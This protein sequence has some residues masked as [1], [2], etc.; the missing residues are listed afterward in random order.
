MTATR[1]CALIPPCPVAGETE[2]NMKYVFKHL[3]GDVIEVE[4]STETWARNE[5]M[6]QKWGPP[7]P[8]TF[9]KPGA[10]DYLVIGEP[11]YFG[12]G[13]DVISVQK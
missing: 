2:Q 12:Y 8:L 9:P 10:K 5:A 11:V 13:L 4:A 6:I 3:G 1:R 7:K